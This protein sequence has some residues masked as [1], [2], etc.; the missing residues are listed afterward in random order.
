LAQLKVNIIPGSRVTGLEPEGGCFRIDL[1]GGKSHRA[2]CVIVALGSN[3]HP[4]LGT[5]GDGYELM[6]RLGHSI[7]TP[8]PT[9]VSM[10][11]P[12]PAFHRLQGLRLQ[13]EGSA[14]VGDRLIA[15]RSG[16]ILFTA[17]GVS[18][19]IVLALSAPLSSRLLDRETLR[20]RL[21]LMPGHDEEMIDH[22]LE[23][24]WSRDP[25]RTLDFSFVGL[26]PKKLGLELVALAQADGA[27]PVGSVSQKIR[28]TLARLMSG[29]DVPIS[30]LGSFQQAEVSGGG[31]STDQVSS[32]TLGSRL[33]KGLFV[34][35]EI[36]DVHGDWGGFNLQFA[37][38]T[39]RIAG[40]SASEK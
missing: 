30:G 16:E 2:M 33:H 26:V 21:N 8:Y 25:G 5:T 24:R 36:L 22:C 18:G 39:G 31:I 32:R 6:S 20:L 12:S 23:K 11:T 1:A 40:L 7:V 38:S 28:R 34:A 9:L 27:A 4:Q 15:S 3:A 14:F 35:G 29:L 19:P 10:L 13:V 37:W 17:Q